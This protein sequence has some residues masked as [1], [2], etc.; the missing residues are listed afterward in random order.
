MSDETCPNCDRPREPDA[1]DCPYCGIV[2]ERF[3]PDRGRRAASTPPPTGAR[4]SAVDRARDGSRLSDVYAGPDVADPGP[5]PD[6][7]LAAPGAPPGLGGDPLSTTVARQGRAT[8]EEARPTKGFEALVVGNPALALLLLFAVYLAVQVFWNSSV[9]GGTVSPT[10]VEARFL[11]LT[12]AAPPPQYEEGARI[13][14]V[15]REFLWFTWETEDVVPA[16]VLVYHLGSLAPE[17]GAEEMVAQFHGWLDDLDLPRKSF[18]KR[19]GRLGSTDAQVEVF[20]L[21]PENRSVAQMAILTFDS[22]AG[23][24]VVMALIGAGRD[25]HE[26]RRQYYR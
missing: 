21:G 2:Y 26:L 5:R 3:D 16:V 17:K 12:G 9:F 24:P 18:G 14:F 10:A 13:H 22:A 1:L 20:G 25:F 6:D 15:G 4:S 19:P 11:E 7:P 8:A 23:E